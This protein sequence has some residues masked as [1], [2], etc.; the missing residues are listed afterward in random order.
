M[1]ER[2]ISDRM[3]RIDASGIRKVFDLAASLDSPINLSIGQPHFDTPE[4]V[5]SACTLAVDT[6]RN[7]YS[8]TQGIKPLVE[9]LQSRADA[10]YGHADRKAFVTS[11]TSGGLMLALCT[12]VNP[13]DEVIVFDPWFVMYKHLTTMAG[14]KVV[15]IPT[16]PDFRID[17]D[18][19]RDAI[20]DRTKVILFN[21][22]ANPT[23]TVAGEEEVRALAELAAEKDVALISDEIYRLFCYDQPFVSPAQFNDQTIVVDGFSKS[24]SMTGWRV[25]WC[26]GP[27]H[28][29]QQML[30]LQQFTFV[31]SPQPLQ[32]GA[33]AA[34]DEDMSSH[35]DE[36][37]KKRNFMRESL[38]EKFDIR[39]ADGAFYMFIKA[40]WGTG[41]EFVRKAIENN[42][43]IIPGNV[44]SE[45]DTHFRLSYAASDETL[46]RGVEVLNRLADEGP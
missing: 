5:R 11:G 46:R 44:F 7:A 28:V 4:A 6:G 34:L 30:K 12:L 32:W 45:S 38:Q 35:V 24:H 10:E 25:G 41:S 40:P 9:A 22:P 19:V 37:R 8:Q 23:G 15:N 16:Y 21:S 27:E 17:V 39:G 1:S 43:L 31:C 14:G 18:R 13:G 33:L 26:H 2:W 3:H 42:L 20:T 36:Y 29:I